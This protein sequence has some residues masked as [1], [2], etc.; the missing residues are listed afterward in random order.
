MGVSPPDCYEQALTPDIRPSRE[1]EA[2][3]TYLPSYLGR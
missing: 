1:D 3:G 2:L